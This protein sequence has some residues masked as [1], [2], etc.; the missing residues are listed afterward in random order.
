M[1]NKTS[2]KTQRAAFS[3]NEAAGQFGKDRSWIYRMV[4]D[5]KIKVIKGY[6]SMMIPTSEI[7]RICEEGASRL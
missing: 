3:L 7:K 2:D 4:K 6:G 5:G 1:S